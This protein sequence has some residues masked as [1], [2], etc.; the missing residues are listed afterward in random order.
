MRHNKPIDRVFGRSI[1]KCMRCGNVKGHI[2]KYGIHLCR[3]CFREV[4]TSIGWK[5]YS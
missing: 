1:K 2:S 3:R 4:A 5:K